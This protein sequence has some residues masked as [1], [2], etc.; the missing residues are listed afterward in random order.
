MLDEVPHEWL[1][2]QVAA[3]VHHGGAGTTAAGLRAGKPTI[4]C[5][6]LGDQAFW[7][8]VVYERGVGPRPIAQ[9]Q[10]SAERLG[11][12]ITTAVPDPMLHR[13]AADIGTKIR[14]EDGVAH[15]VAIISRIMGS[16]RRGVW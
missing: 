1:F 3:V 9:Q 6:L 2:P 14:T 4:S 8:R 12:A 10:V 11:D 16:L 5:P 7:G 13:E 15:A